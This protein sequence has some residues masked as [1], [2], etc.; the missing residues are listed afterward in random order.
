MK[1]KRLS[2]L[3]SAVMVCGIIFTGC[4]S[5]D[6]PNSKKVAESSSEAA[7]KKENENSS[8]TTSKKK[9][10]NSSD[11]TSKKEDNS[12]DNEKESSSDEGKGTLSKIKNAL[13]ET[14]K[15]I[16]DDI[17]EVKDSDKN[18]DGKYHPGDV[19]SFG[20]FKITYKSIAKYKS[21]NQ[22]IQPKKGFQYIKYVF[23]FKNTGKSDSYVGN[24]ACYADGEQCDSA[25]VDDSDS[26]LLLTK[27]SSGRKKSG[28]LVYEV[29]KNVKLKDIELEYENNSLWSDEKIIFL[30][31]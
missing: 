15:E 10:K 3:L 27:L 2:I 21:S 20:D 24:F 19:A 1:I 26:S 11:T 9:N 16:T 7:S 5:T 18:K 28:S 13:K 6:T 12:S 14:A 29:P 17:E 22:F 8:D 23:S 25:Y 4:T 31:K 30:G